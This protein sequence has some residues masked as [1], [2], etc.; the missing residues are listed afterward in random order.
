M[1]E[2]I[3]A[4]RHPSPNGE[5]KVCL[6]VNGK[7]VADLPY[8]V[9]MQF[10]KQLFGLGKLIENDSNIEKTIADQSVLMRA[11]AAL[12]LTSNPKVLSEAHKEAQWNKDLRKY[13]PN[14]P[15]VPSKAILGI[16]TVKRGTPNGTV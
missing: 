9:A 3:N 4:I 2:E 8:Q 5:D 14:A 13:M 15:G 6:I 7:L 16:P 11:G 12:G 10:G 1:K